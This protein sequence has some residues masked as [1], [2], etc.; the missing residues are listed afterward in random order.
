MS[1]DPASGTPR[2]VKVVGL[3]V[4]LL[5]LLAVL[6]LVGGHGPGLHSP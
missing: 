2:W 1:D 5:L 3:I 4:I 6:L